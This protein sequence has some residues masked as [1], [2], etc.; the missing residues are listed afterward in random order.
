[1]I[2]QEQILEIIQNNYNEYKGSNEAE[3]HSSEE[4]YDLFFKEQSTKKISYSRLLGEYIGT[5][6]G[7]IHNDI[8]EDLKKKLE[9]KIKEL[10]NDKERN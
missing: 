2:T 9:T 5:L 10:E 1:M 3:L 6:K 7:I 4:I 8:P